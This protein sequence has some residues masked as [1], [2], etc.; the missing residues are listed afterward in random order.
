MTK[1][2]QFMALV[3]VILAVMVL[4]MHIIFPNRTINKRKNH[5]EYRTITKRRK[6]KRK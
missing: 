1:E 5:F 6:V 2:E 3:C 4:L